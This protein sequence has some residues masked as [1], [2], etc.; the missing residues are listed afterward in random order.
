V[1]GRP[2]E[3]IGL[4]GEVRKARQVIA[5]PDELRPVADPR[6]DLLPDGTN[7]HN[8]AIANEVGESGSVG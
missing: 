5:Q 6:Q 1:L 8:F 7:Q 4:K 3:V 2:N